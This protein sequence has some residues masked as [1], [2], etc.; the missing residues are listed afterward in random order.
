[1]GNAELRVRL[2]RAMVL[3]PSDLGVFALGDVGRVWV[4]GETSDRWHG[5]VGGG[6]WLT[7]ARPGNT[8][9]VAVA[10]GAEKTALYLRAGF[11]Y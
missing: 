2:T 1:V 8:L 3:V 7:F 11:A 10:Q 5:A 4:E 9:S 6:I